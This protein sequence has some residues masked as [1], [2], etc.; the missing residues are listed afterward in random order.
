[1]NGIALPRQIV[2]SRLS[3]G[4]AGAAA[5]AFSGGG[6]MAEGRGRAFL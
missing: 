4:A 5:L 1:L 2:H 3:H 6:S